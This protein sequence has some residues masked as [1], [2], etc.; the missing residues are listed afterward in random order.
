MI[1]ALANHHVLPHDGKGITKAMAVSA[2]TTAI[3]LDSTIATVFASGALTAN[4]DHS[5]HSFDL[6]M[7]DKHGLIEHDVSL[8][9]SDFA[10]GDNHTFDKEVWE[11]VLKTYEG[12]TETDFETVS[13]ARYGRVV[14]SK[15]KMEAAGKGKEWVYGIKEFILSY[16][17]SALF[18]GILGDPKNGQIPLEYLKVLFEQERLPFNEG[19]RPN[20]KAVT[21]GDMNHLIFK[22]IM[23]NE[24]KAAEASDVGL[25]SIHAVTNAVTSI[26]P[27]YCTIM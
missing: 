23:A 17:E 1:N 4:P 11:G 2:L 26:M 12:K 25:G 18:L 6:D 15:K 3:N 9:R 16:G 8:S 5:S 13:K 10:L 19:W 22:L 21:Q 27:T 7:V 24:H 14:A 20:A